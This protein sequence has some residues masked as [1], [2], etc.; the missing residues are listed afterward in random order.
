[1]DAPERRPPAPDGVIVTIVATAV[2]PKQKSGRSA[3]ADC[4]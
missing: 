3:T 1:M 4:F 2:E